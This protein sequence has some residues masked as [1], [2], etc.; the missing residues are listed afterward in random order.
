MWLN[1]TPSA[2]PEFFRRRTI[3]W[4]I[5]SC[6]WKLSCSGLIYRLWK[7]MQRFCEKILLLYSNRIRK[8]V[9]RMFKNHL[10]MDCNINWLLS[11]GLL[12]TMTVLWEKR[13]KQLKKFWS[14][15]CSNITQKMTN[16]RSLV[17]FRLKTVAIAFFYFYKTGQTNT[18]DL[19]AYVSRFR[20]ITLLTQ[21]SIKKKSFRKTEK[22]VGTGLS[23]N[24][25]EIKDLI[26]E[27]NSFCLDLAIE[28]GA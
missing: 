24:A 11:L 13:K 27:N 19:F 22:K 25:L 5:F 4:A 1:I 21:N 14:F 12:Q 6:N 17:F 2:K 16:T 10:Q 28:K 18:T 8:W 7:L 26:N 23:K 20:I 9:L 15:Q 3:F